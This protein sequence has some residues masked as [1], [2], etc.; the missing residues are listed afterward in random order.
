MSDARPAGELRFSLCTR[1]RCPRT[2]RASAGSV[3]CF[4]S[5]RVPGGL[6][7]NVDLLDADVPDAG[8]KDRQD[9]GVVGAGIEGGVHK[10]DRNEDAI[11]RAEN[12][13]FVLVPMLKAPGE[14]INHLFLTRVV[15]EGV[16]VAGGEGS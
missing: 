4:N 7:G 2:T 13:L 14:H 1:G 6:A 8:S 12:A 3:R 16:S 5:Q 15:M 10:P 11:A 9:L